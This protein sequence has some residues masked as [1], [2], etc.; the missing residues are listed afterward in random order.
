MT[1]EQCNICAWFDETEEKRIV[2]RSKFFTLFFPKDPMVYREDGGHLIVVPNRHVIDL[3]FF[4]KDESL[5][6][7]AFLRTA[8]EI[9]YDCVPTFSIPVGRVNYHDNGNLEAD[10]KAG[11]HQH[12]HIY[13][14]SRNAI[15][16]KW[17]SHLR[18]PDWNPN[19]SYYIEASHFTDAEK[20]IIRKFARTS[21]PRNLA[22]QMTSL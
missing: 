21:F 17:K 15:L 18:F 9:M 5:E 11:A 2:L 3:R 14:R 7:M 13:G 22:M 12:M 16:Q 6:Y 20:E 1:Q 10:K 4:S 8:S 19:D